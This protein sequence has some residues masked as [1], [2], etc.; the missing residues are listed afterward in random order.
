M[1]QRSAFS[2]R[3]LKWWDRHGRKDLPWQREPTPYRVWVSEI[4]LQ[5]TQVATV[6]PYYTRFMARFPTVAELADA[7]LDEVLHRW[8]GLGYY[9][10]ARNLSAAA[11]QIQQRWGGELPRT[12]AELMT[13]P[14]IGRS[15][16]A[17]ILALA[18]DQPLAILDGNV[19]RVLSRYHAVAGWPGRREVEQR[20]WAYAEAHTPPHRAAHYTQAIMDLGATV[21]T[22]RRPRCDRCPFGSD[23]AARRAGRVA[24]HPGPKP[25]RQLPRRSTR[26]LLIENAAGAVLLLKR[27]PAGLWGGLWGLPECPL[28]TAPA[29]WCRQELGLDIEVLE[30]WP[31]VRH[32]FSHYH[33]DI[34][35]SRA[36]A[37]QCRGVMEGPPALWYNPGQSQALGLA[38]PVQTLLQRFQSVTKKGPP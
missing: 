36:R 13:L 4:M 3:L 38:A 30:N 8:S 21:C 1:T 16:A 28:E 32:S 12:Q 9:A 6:I 34:H 18:M 5:Q 25:R 19:K 31:L 23:C 29:R 14:G 15:T 17:A 7:A 37:G 2:R 35:P 10:R 33:L 26:M 20:L 24:D 22:R 11:R 27:P